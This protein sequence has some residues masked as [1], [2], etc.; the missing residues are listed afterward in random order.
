MAREH[1]LDPANRT[2]DRPLSLVPGGKSKTPTPRRYRLAHL[3]G[4][5]REAARVYRLVASGQL[6]SSEGSRLIYML[7][8]IGR[9]TVDAC[10]EDRLSRL[11]QTL[12]EKRYD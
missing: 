7:D 10:L 4:V 5:Q 9:L 2:P 11:E 6:E 12:E 1:S 3:R 8:R